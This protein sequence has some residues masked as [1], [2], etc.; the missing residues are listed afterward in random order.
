M[1]LWYLFGAV[2]LTACCLVVLLGLWLFVG[3][4]LVPALDFGLAGV[5]LCFAFGLL[6]FVRFGYLSYDFVGFGLLGLLVGGF[7]FGLGCF[8]L[9]P[10]S[11]VMC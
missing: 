3:L 6:Q 8:G 2:R 7:E 4:W 9:L 5:A 10:L 11:C 1:V